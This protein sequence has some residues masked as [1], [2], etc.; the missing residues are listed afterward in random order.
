MENNNT[1][2]GVNTILIVVLLVLVVGFGVW[3]FTGGF[4]GNTAPAE[5]EAQFNLNVDVP[6]GGNDEPN[7]DETAQ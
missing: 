2:S 3:Y 1:N 6:T 4:G 7:G 5:D